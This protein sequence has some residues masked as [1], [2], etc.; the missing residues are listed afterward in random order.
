MPSSFV[1]TQAKPIVRLMGYGVSALT[2]LEGEAFVKE[3]ARPSKRL[4]DKRH[5][6]KSDEGLVIG[7][8]S[9]ARVQVD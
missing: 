7:S 9:T 3:G 5:L 4:S 6:V 8:L 2:L 1:L